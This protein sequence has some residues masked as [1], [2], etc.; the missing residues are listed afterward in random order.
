[1]SRL[2]NDHL[3]LP[4]S[5]ALFVGLVVVVAPVAQAQPLLW[6]C[7]P[8]SQQINCCDEWVWVYEPCG[9][10]ES[11]P[12]CWTD[13]TQTFFWE[14][15]MAFAPP[16]HQ[17]HEWVDYPKAHLGGQNVCWTALSEESS[18]P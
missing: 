5:V 3:R 18:G 4:V 14:S 10:C 6:T 11:G 17:C 7:F 16:G 13:C 15:C 1:M 9:W 8:Y 12:Y 2:L